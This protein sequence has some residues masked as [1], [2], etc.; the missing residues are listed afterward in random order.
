MVARQRPRGYEEGA[1]GSAADASARSR[2]RAR[3]VTGG[4]GERAGVVI[5]LVLLA[6][7]AISLTGLP[8]APR[9]AGTAL[10][11]AVGLAA[12]GV[13]ARAGRRLR[14]EHAAL[15]RREADARRLAELDELTG[16]GNYRRFT[17]QLAAE[18]ARSRRHEDPF[19]LILLDL[20]GFKAINDEL[21]HLAGDDAL[22]DVAEALRDTLREEDVCCRQGGDE[23]AVIA[24]RAGAREAEELSH[25]LTDAIEQIPFGPGGRRRLTACAGWATFGAPARSADELILEADAALRAAKRSGDAAEGD[26]RAATAPRRPPARLGRAETMRLALLTGLSRALAGVRT[27]RALADTTVAY[28]AGALDGIGAAV[29]AFAPSAASRP[30]S[31]F[32]ALSTGPAPPDAER[33][34]TDRASVMHA[35]AAGGAAVVE[36]DIAARWVVGGGP[37]RSELAVAVTDGEETTWGCL[38]VVSDRPRAFGTADR[39]LA[40]A[41]AQQLGR[42][43]ACNRLLERLSDSSFGELYRLAAAVDGQR[44][45]GV[46]A[47]AG[48]DGAEE[49]RL[50]DLAWQVG[51][52]CQL[53]DRSLRALYVAA[54]FHNVGMVGVPAA[55]PAYP[56]EL[57]EEERA[58]VR[59]HP[60]IGERMLRSLPLLRDAAPIVRHARERWDGAGGPDGLGRDEIPLPAR[61]L[62]ACDVYVSLTSP[63]PWRPA[64]SHAAACAELR[65]VAGAQLDPDVVD[66]LLELLSV[67]GGGGVPRSQPAGV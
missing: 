22:R 54:L 4:A 13:A 20:D 19:S 51:R 57:R 58:I 30:T 32:V 61:I 9:A 38:L 62:F 42:A 40:E 29:I 25:R 1:G 48:G 41:I 59:E 67:G 36:D 7:V 5:A 17:R 15:A 14:R 45:A 39:A 33:A 66:R 43:I 24:V 63:R 60:R 65:R 26:G 37:V 23:F 8:P 28:L 56:G 64:R 18:V 44:P 6:L 21:G 46:G 2:G 47:G 55:L 27:E 49:W 53:D 35:C 16:L 11:A 31:R 3:S 34:L 12:V 52:D 50:A 10:L